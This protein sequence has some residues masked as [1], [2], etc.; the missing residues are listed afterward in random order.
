MQMM[1]TPATDNGQAAMMKFMPL[2]F[3]AFC[4]N[5][6]SGLALYWTVSNLYTIGQQLVINR[7]KDP[8]PEAPAS[9]AGPKNVTPADKRPKKK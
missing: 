3:V 6:G 8:E 9:A 5:F 4:Y 2:I 1:P 7:M